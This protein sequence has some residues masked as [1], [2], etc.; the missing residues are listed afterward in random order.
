M[1]EMGPLAMGTNAAIYQHAQL[2]KDQ[3]IRS[4]FVTGT[5]PHPAQMPPKHCALRADSYCH[6]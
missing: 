3:S 2:D 6:R 1:R 4:T 5:V